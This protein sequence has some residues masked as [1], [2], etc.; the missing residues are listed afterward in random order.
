[1]NYLFWN[2]R[3][4]KE[5][6]PNINP[7]LKDLIIENKCDM[8][9]LAEYKSDINELLKSLEGENVNMY[10]IKQIACKRIHIITKFIPERIEHLPESDKY[11]IKKVPHNNLDS[12]TV[13]CVHLPSKKNSDSHTHITEIGYLIKDIRE[14]EIEEN[15][16]N[17]IIV[18]DFNL[19]P[20]EDEM[21]SALG[22]HAVSSKKEA[23]K[24]SR[25][26]QGREYF[27]FYNPM[28]NL[29]GDIE[30]PPGTYYYDKES[31]IR[32]YWYILDQVIIRPSIIAHFNDNAL[33]IITKTKNFDLS[34][35]NYKPHKDSISDHFPIYF[36][37]N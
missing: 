11:T 18:G 22:C 34:K 9:I 26:I 3:E 27:M 17:T 24:I 1:M 30:S 32:P 36:E 12:I 20:F 19:N 5:I 37:I 6:N 31:Y 21:V 7:I 35:D 33:K 2:T 28:W 4:V 16:N 14:Y 29:L 8:V 13:A 15:D 25:I 10:K 23:I